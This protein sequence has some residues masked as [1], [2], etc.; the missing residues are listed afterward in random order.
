M[1]DA[2]LRHIMEHRNYDVVASLHRTLEACAIS[3]KKFILLYD[4]GTCSAVN[5]TMGALGAVDFVAHESL[6]K[7]A[8]HVLSF[9][10]MFMN[11][12]IECK[13]FIRDQTGTAQFAASLP[14]ISASAVY[15]NAACVRVL[16]QATLVSTISSGPWQ[17]C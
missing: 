14:R 6:V 8:T 7:E 10:M 12:N 5:A 13:N 17:S 3:L 4:Q 2:M 16:F 11:D 15:S 9:L 1:Q